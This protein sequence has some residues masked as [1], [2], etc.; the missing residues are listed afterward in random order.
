M[1]EERLAIGD[2][3]Y[4]TI[5]DDILKDELSH[6]KTDYGPMEEYFNDETIVELVIFFLS[7]LFVLSLLLYIRKESK[8]S[9]AIDLLLDQLAIKLNS[10]IPSL[11]DFSH[12]RLSDVFRFHLIILPTEFVTL[13]PLDLYLQIHTHW[14]CLRAQ[15]LT[16]DSSLSEYL[17]CMQYNLSKA[18]YFI[19]YLKNVE[20]F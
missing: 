3:N 13:M 17:T 9:H 14:Y 20:V 10:W 12:L 5:T 16:N 7:Y 4:L 11:C 1:Q 6:I 15:I 19:N 18:I 8:L 2:D